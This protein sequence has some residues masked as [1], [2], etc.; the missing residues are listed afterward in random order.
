MNVTWR[1]L[2]STLLAV[3]L[4]T[5]CGGSS[6]S[7]S[8][9]TT[10]TTPPATTTVGA[11]VTPIKHLVVIF[12]ENISFDHYFG[13]YP[14]AANLPGE[15]AF[16][17]LPGT[18]TVN[19]YTTALLTQNPNLNSLNG[20]GATNPFRL[21]PSQA[22]TADQDNDYSPEQQ[23]FDDGKLDLFPSFTG[24]GG[25]ALGT[26]DPGAPAPFNTS[27][28]ALGYYDGNTVTALWNYAQHYAMSD[29][30]FETTFGDSTLG[31]INLVSGQ[32][33]GVSDIVNEDD[34]F[35]DGGKQID[36]AGWRAGP[37][38]RPVLRT[39]PRLK[40]RWAVRTSAT[41]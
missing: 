38:R 31:A 15:Q 36:D 6:S 33:N 39:P 37:P 1:E 13:T 34:E 26:P 25:N 19:G 7:T 30:T 3:S 11:A 21:S 41:C 35:V 32:T 40:P 23:A 5:G 24:A 8:S 16:T 12:D 4:I 10:T 29:N 9:G 28:L 27:G 17:S 2:T 22:S 20:A 14:N 18:P